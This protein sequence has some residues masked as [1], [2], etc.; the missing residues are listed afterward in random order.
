MK[1]HF[2]AYRESDTSYEI[3]LT[4]VL[5]EVSQLLEWL[6][7]AV[8]VT[9]LN[10]IHGIGYRS[11]AISTQGFLSEGYVQEKFSC[12]DADVG[13]LT[14]AIRQALGMTGHSLEN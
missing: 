9:W 11:Y 3:L 13:G 10:P 8:L 2:L 14:R 6:P 5:P 12:S 4:E 1:T 7:S